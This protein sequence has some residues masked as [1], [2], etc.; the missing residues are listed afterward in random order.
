M[1]G[2]ICGENP[3]RIH[4]FV[5]EYNHQLGKSGLDLS[6]NDVD[7]THDYFSKENMVIFL[8]LKYWRFMKR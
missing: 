3:H 2:L 7:S 8:T 5:W 6:T 4:E 1:I